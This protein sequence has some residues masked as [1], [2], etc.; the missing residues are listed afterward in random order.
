[1][2]FERFWSKVRF[3][4]GCW[5]WLAGRDHWGYGKFAI[6]GQKRGAHR[7]SYELAVGPIP[8]GLTIDHLCRNPGCVNPRHMEPVPIKENLL[9]GFGLCAQNARKTHCKEGHEFT[10]LNTYFRLEGR[11]ECRICK[12]RM[13]REFRQRHKV[14]V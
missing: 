9:R 4:D 1:M 13:K 10:L 5:E 2:I 3:S 8:E 7:V 12:R 11:R 14:S 6:A